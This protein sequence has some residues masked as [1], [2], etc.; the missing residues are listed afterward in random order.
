MEE[1]TKKLNKEDIINILNDQMKDFDPNEYV[2]V[3]K[4]GL[5]LRD[6]IS[7]CNDIDVEISKNI[8]KELNKR[9]IPFNI[10]PS[11]DHRYQLG[12][13]LEAFYSG[14]ER[15]VQKTEFV[16]GFQCTELNEAIDTYKKRNR[17]KD[18]IT[19]KLLADKLSK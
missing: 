9:F 15:H 17:P 11:G 10:A 18:I 8:A 7:E 14:G 5:V 3:Y 2:I 4:A 13:R 6:L 19:L 12:D 1:F 16:H